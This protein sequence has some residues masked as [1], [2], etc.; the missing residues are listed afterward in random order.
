VCVCADGCDEI[1]VF[2]AR[3]IVIALGSVVDVSRI[4]GMS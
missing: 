1:V 4:P 2:A 3:H